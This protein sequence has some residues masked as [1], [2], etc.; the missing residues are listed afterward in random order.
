MI[1]SSIHLQVQTDV[2]TIFHF[3]DMFH[4]LLQSHQVTEGVCRAFMGCLDS[5]FSLSI[6]TAICTWTQSLL[7]L[8]GDFSRLFFQSTFTMLPPEKNQSAVNAYAY[9]IL[10]LLNLAAS[11]LYLCKRRV[12]SF[13]V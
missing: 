13:S 12:G 6:R 1:T 7:G 3:S 4:V 8:Y 9:E 11:L 2:C 5:R 10:C